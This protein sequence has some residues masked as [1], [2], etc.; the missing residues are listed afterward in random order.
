MGT[1]STTARITRHGSSGMLRAELWVALAV[2]ALC[3]VVLLA[4]RYGLGPAEPRGPDIVT[5]QDAGKIQDVH[6]Q[7]AALGSETTVRTSLGIYQVRGGVSVA[8]G[9]AAKLRRTTNEMDGKPLRN[10]LE[11]CVESTIKSS[12]YELL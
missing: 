5:E 6:L 1:P 12:C 3:V 10:K 2:V 7:S 8:I 4:L 9:D 11:L